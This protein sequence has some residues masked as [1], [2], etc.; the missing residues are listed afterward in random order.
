MG[1]SLGRPPLRR[2]PRS[3]RVRWGTFGWD[4]F[5]YWN[6]DAA[7][8]YQAWYDRPRA[9]LTAR[10]GSGMSLMHRLPRDLFQIVWP[11]MLALVDRIAG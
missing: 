1:C 7:D 5:A 2:H 8:P 10:C 11:V 6:V 3:T 9:F 4:A